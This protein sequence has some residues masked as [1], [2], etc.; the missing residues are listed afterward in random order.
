MQ[1]DLDA[2]KKERDQKV[3]EYQQRLEKER[4][5]FNHKKR[6]LD[7]RGAT[8]ESKHTELLLTH[9]KERAKWDQ[10]LTDL[11]HQREDFKSENDRLKVK[12]DTQFKEIEKLKLEA[13]NA[14]KS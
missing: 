5:Q 3:H 2:A 11:I 4:E 14:R 12:V 1:E 7:Q 8:R 13:R 9:E 10:Q 6:E